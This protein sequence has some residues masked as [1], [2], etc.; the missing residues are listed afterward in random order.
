[1]ADAH[2]PRERVPLYYG[3]SKDTMTAAAWIAKV[4]RLQIANN[5]TQA[6]TLNT[7]GN[8]LRETCEEWFNNDIAGNTQMT[9]TTFKT[10]FL[11]F[12][13]VLTTSYLGFTHWSTMMTPRGTLSLGDYYNKIVS[14][15]RYWAQTI[16]QDPVPDSL[17]PPVPD[18][19]AMN[20]QM[21]AVPANIRAAFAEYY[22][23]RGAQHTRGHVL[24]GLFYGGLHPTTKEHLADKN[25]NNVIEMRNEVMKFEKTRLDLG[26]P[27]HAIEG[28]DAVRARQQPRQQDNRRQSTQPRNQDYKKGAICHYCKKANHFQKEC[29]KRARD[30][31]PMVKQPPRKVNP[32]EETKQEKD[33]VSAFESNPNH[34]NYV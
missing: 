15:N 21:Q 5:W 8:A 25:F 33:N 20:A 17:D 22:Q 34:L 2:E 1:M 7:A 24:M 4:D 6:I 19:V 16:P 30:K 10:H 27:V 11:Q 26:L 18:V 12:Q 3:N 14:S 29:H 32:V 28:V 23:D 9:W 31:A 13:G